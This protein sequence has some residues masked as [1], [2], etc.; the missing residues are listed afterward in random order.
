MYG[1]RIFNIY[2]INL[3]LILKMILFNYANL[4]Q[5][6]T[7]LEHNMSDSSYVS[8]AYINKDSLYNE[9]DQAVSRLKTNKSVG[10]DV[11][12]NEI[13]KFE[14]VKQAMSEIRRTHM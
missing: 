10:V 7:Q 6:K 11:I 2:I 4:L 14:D 12:P 8:N 13:L 5:N 1:R 9:M 3:K